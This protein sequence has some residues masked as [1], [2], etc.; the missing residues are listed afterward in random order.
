MD[1]P[2]QIVKAFPINLVY[3]S[4]KDKWNKRP[5]IPRGQDWHTYE[6]TKK[7]MAHAKNIG[8]IIPEGIVLIDVDTH[9]GVNI[10]DI[11]AALGCKLDWANAHVQNTPSGGAHY[12]FTIPT[13][14]NI[15]Q[16]SDLLGV[17]GFDTRTSGNGWIATGDNYED[18]TFEGLPSAL[19]DDVWPELPSADRG[20]TTTTGRTTG[21][22]DEQRTTTAT[23][24]TTGH[25]GTRRDGRREDLHLY[26]IIKFQME[27]WDQVSNV[28]INRPSTLRFRHSQ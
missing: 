3:D 10:S 16:G 22:T 24:T 5:A 26:M 2:M 23:T 12:A 28:T 4:A 15:R 20:R 13:C 1:M 11:D 7:E 21:R 14:V 19:C 27:H 18:L 6:S 17:K 8:V 9:K 25:D